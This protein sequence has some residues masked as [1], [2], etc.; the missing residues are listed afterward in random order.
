M[1]AFHRF[2]TPSIAFD[3]RPDHK[4]GFNPIESLYNARFDLSKRIVTVVVPGAAAVIP[5]TP[6]KATLEVAQ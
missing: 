2:L 4:V 3:N 5:P 6:V 1:P